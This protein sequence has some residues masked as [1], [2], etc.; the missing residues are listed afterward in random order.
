MILL[1][2]MIMFYGGYYQ[3]SFIVATVVQPDRV[4]FKIIFKVKLKP[5]QYCSSGRMLEFLGLGFY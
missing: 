3:G 2:E 4:V 1:A 5:N